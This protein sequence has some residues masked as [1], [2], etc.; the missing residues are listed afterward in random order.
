MLNEVAGSAR[1]QSRGIAD[2]NRSVSELDQATQQNAALVEQSTTAAAAL[3][4]QAEQ[5]SYSMATFELE[6]AGR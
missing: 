2:V 1:E 6:S 4:E 5:L 3:K